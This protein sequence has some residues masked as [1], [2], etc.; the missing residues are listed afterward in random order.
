MCRYLY[1][2]YKFCCLRH[3]LLAAQHFPHQGGE[4]IS[5]SSSSRVFSVLFH[6][7]S[8]SCLKFDDKSVTGIWCLVRK[9]NGSCMNFLNQP[10]CSRSLT[11]KDRFG[12]NSM[13]LCIKMP[14]A[15]TNS[16]FTNL[17]KLCIRIMKRSIDV[18]NQILVLWIRICIICP[19]PYLY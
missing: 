19:D 10:V 18:C 15:L 8:H 14:K 7:G 12:P 9:Q 5:R 6:F 16:S 17:L 3:L 2:Y 13:K 11:K 4:T 1:P